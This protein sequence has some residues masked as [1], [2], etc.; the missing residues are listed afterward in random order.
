M[1]NEQDKVNTDF[2]KNFD[3]L[4]RKEITWT[5]MQIQCY[6]TILVY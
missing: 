6:I 2:K 5:A 1:E 4:G 3:E